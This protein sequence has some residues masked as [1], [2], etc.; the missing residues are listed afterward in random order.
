MELWVGMK[1]LRHTYHACVV[2]SNPRPHRREASYSQIKTVQ[3]CGIWWKYTP[4]FETISSSSFYLETE[5]ALFSSNYELSCAHHFFQ[6]FG[7][8][9]CPILFFHTFAQ[10]FD[11]LY[12]KY[13]RE[14]IFQS[15][16]YVCDGSMFQ[17]IPRVGIASYLWHVREF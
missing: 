11:L 13:A 2:K 9:M 1:I 8:F 10:P 12:Q 5:L 17:R 15:M 3:V 6:C 16:E 4:L 14:I 7:T